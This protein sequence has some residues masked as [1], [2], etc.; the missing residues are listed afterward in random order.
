MDIE[1]IRKRIEQLRELIRFHNYRY[2][3]LDQPEISDR[4]YDSLYRELETLEGQYPQFYEKN[5]PTQ[6]VGEKITGGFKTITHTIPMLSIANTYSH[7]EVREFDARVKRMLDIGENEDIEYVAELK[8]DGVAISLRYEN[9]NLVYGSTRG[10][11]FT[12]DDVTLNIRTIKSIPLSIDMSNLKGGGFIEIRGEVY[13]N[14]DDFERINAE[15]EKNEEIL[16]ANPRNLT[17]GSL[18]LLDPQITAARPLKAFLYAI[19][20]A[21]A[22][23]PDTHWERLKIISELG[24]PVNKSNLLCKNVEEVIKHCTEWETRRKTIPYDMDG[25]VIKVNNIE[26][27]GR[28]GSTAKNPRWLIAYKFSAEQAETKLLDIKLQVGRTG[29]VTPVAVLEPVFLAGSQISRAT[30]HNE[31][32]I[33]RKDIRIGDIVVI[34]KGGEVIPKVVGVK[35]SL[36]TGKEK[37]FVMPAECPVC[38]SPLKRSEHEVAVRCENINC[39]AQIKERIIHFVSRNAMDIVGFGNKIVDLLVDNKILTDFTDFYKIKY[40]QI[41]NLERMGPKSAQNLIDAIEGSKHQTLARFIFALGIRYVGAQTAKLLA[42]HFPTIDNII[43]STREE[44]EAIEGIGTVVAE[45]IRAFFDTKEN[46]D[47]VYKLLELG[48]TLTNSDYVSEE[49]QKFKNPD[50]AGKTFVLTGAL[51]SM[52]R[53]EAAQKIESLG[54]KVSSSVSSKTDYVVVGTEPGSKLAKA[55]QLGVKILDEAEFIKQ[56]FQ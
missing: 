29:A 22:K 21:D 44:L 45:S 3:V 8:I 46:L 34:E 53:D 5:S 16:Y 43:S 31:D 55:Q 11:G 13:M 30:L 26:Y 7:N 41:I 17:S 18:K 19:G 51:S 28:L 2:Y 6:R 49:N 20:A 54:G 36:R 37:P 12:G 14:R 35:E 27:E 4:E 9:G 24:F 42:S 33:K 23:L 15:R 25:L 47:T 52:T 32:E 38:R 40:E 48:I 1:E 56:L 50:V 10:D 39:P